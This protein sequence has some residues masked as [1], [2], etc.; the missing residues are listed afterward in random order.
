M[1]DELGLTGTSF[2][3]LAN[4]LFGWEG[5]AGDAAIEST[6]EDFMKLAVVALR[7][8]SLPTGKVLISEHNWNKWAMPNL[9]PSCNL[10]KDLVSWQGPP[11]SWK[12][13]NV[14]GV[15]ETVMRQSGEYGWNYF[16]ATYFGSQEI[17]WCGF[18]S[19]CLRV[20]YVADVAFVMMQ[21]DV[22]D[23]KRSKPHL[24]TNFDTMARS[25]QCKQTGC[26]NKTD[27]RPHPSVFCHTCTGPGNGSCVEKP[28]HDSQCKQ[29][30][31]GAQN[32]FLRSVSSWLSRNHSCYVPRCPSEKHLVPHSCWSGFEVYRDK[33]GRTPDWASA[34]CMHTLTLLLL[35]AAYLT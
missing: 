6:A 4:H 15:K 17:G 10:S 19:S 1:F 33:I 16:G 26:R 8:G 22:A 5:D 24:N 7:K 12:N 30:S 35:C 32:V 28:Q 23:L 3:S 21:R 2:K 9:L 31:H 20:S 13:G 14:A 25:L 11:S 18:F 34:K 29:R 27:R